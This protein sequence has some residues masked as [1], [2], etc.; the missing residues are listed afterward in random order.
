MFKHVGSL[1]E[2]ISFF[3]DSCAKSYLL[4]D[5]CVDICVWW[6]VFF[7]VFMCIT[8]AFFFFSLFYV[9]VCLNSLEDIYLILFDWSQLILIVVLLFYLVETNTGKRTAIRSRCLLQ[10]L[11]LNDHQLNQCRNNDLTSTENNQP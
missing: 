6:F 5:D 9:C 11:M 2:S 8:D 3:V 7:F 1:F 4:I 10:R